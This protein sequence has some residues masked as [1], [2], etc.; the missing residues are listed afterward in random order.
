[1]T[2]TVDPRAFAIA[3]ELTNQLS[4][5]GAFVDEHDSSMDVEYVVIS[6]SES[7][8][9]TL[10]S[11]GVLVFRDAIPDN[12]SVDTPLASASTR[13]FDTAAPCGLDPSL[14]WWSLVEQMTDVSPSSSVEVLMA[15]D[16]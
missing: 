2:S 13:T 1:M 14:T 3:I 9:D 5:D 16:W 4:S 8:S 10:N 15:M 6:D 7:E 11:D 12:V